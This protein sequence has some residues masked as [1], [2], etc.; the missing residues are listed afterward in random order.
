MFWKCCAQYLERVVVLEVLCTVLGKGS[1]SGSFVLS[2]WSGYLFCK[3]SAQ[4][5]ERILVL[6]VL[7]TV[8]GEGSCSGSVVHS[9]WRG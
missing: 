9:T 1:C 3:C 2:N 7:C 8:L 5:M 4:Y 6:E